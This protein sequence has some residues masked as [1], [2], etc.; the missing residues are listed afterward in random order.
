MNLMYFFQQNS[1]NL[2]VHSESTPAISNDSH[3]NFCTTKDENF[4]PRHL[5][6]SKS[7]PILM[8]QDELDFSYAFKRSEEDEMMFTISKANEIIVQKFR[9]QLL[10]E[11]PTNITLVNIKTVTS[12][13]AGK[14][15]GI[16][17]EVPKSN[18][19]FSRAEIESK[20][21]V[22]EQNSSDS[23]MA[24]E[25]ASNDAP[26]VLNKIV[27][28][29]KSI[30]DAT[31]QEN[32][33]LPSRLIFFN[34]PSNDVI[35]VC[36]NCATA[37]LVND[38]LQELKIRNVVSSNHLLVGH[39]AETQT[40]ILINALN[41][42]HPENQ[43][44]ISSRQNAIE[45]E[46]EFVLASDRIHTLIST[47]AEDRIM[48]ELSQ[49]YR[50]GNKHSNLIII[51]SGRDAI[52][53]HSELKAMFEKACKNLEHA[54][55]KIEGYKK[56]EFDVFD[57]LHSCEIQLC[58]LT[59]DQ[60]VVQ[61]KSNLPDFASVLSKIR[62]SLFKITLNVL[63]ERMIYSESYHTCSKEKDEQK[64]QLDQ[65][66]QR[67]SIIEQEIQNRIADSIKTQNA[68]FQLERENFQKEVE[69]LKICNEKLRQLILSFN[70]LFKSIHSS[71]ALA[72]MSANSQKSVAL[73][74]ESRTFYSPEALLSLAQKLKTTT[75]EKINLQNQVEE[76][77]A[78]IAKLKQALEMV[79][80][81]R[82]TERA[83]HLFLKKKMSVSLG[84]ATAL[85]ASLSTPAPVSD[86]KIQEQSSADL[87]QS[88]TIQ[89]QSALKGNLKSGLNTFSAV[90]RRNMRVGSK[91]AIEFL[92]PTIA[93]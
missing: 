5:F 55:Q 90:V 57:L 86:A 40:E 14:Y 19:D 22:S 29:D 45:I 21:K 48:I 46:R 89:F 84:D 18:F 66:L 9:D 15:K 25:K 53:N 51:N 91:A 83:A 20:P 38:L 72:P 23:L 47:Q 41:Y 6:A 64:H 2:F 78:E 87:A 58:L 8:N 80:T 32:P 54:C 13:K 69:S 63:H 36:S 4:I 74:N 35:I 85:A 49:L 42:S 33:K 7:V 73:Q 30:W 77:D 56:V 26:A 24:N 12:P 79:R 62:D 50:L 59:I 68:E 75:Q 71:L 31:F 60:L 1:S 92:P 65:A 61:F 70:S 81:E 52:L 37:L 82:N 11:K 16:E 76:K 34:P 10:S 28:M 88:D 44:L 39:E 93:E 67:F 3:P 43:D 17:S 27:H